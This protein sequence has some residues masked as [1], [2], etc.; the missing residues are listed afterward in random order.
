MRISY[1]GIVFDDYGTDSDGHYWTEICPQCA[2]KYKNIITN[3]LDDGGTAYGVCSVAGCN[4]AADYYF[5]CDDRFAV[6]EK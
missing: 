2:E 5:D 1:K 4:N 6:T 3:E